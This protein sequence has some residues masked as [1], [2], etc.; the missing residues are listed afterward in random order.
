MS[1]FR[2]YVKR[3]H[4]GL[5]ALLLVLTGGT[6]YAATAIPK[7]AVGSKHVKDNSLRGKDLKDAGLTGADLADGSVAGP[8]LADGSVGGADL[9]D[10]G[11]GAGDLAAGSVDGGAIKDGAVGKADIADDVVPQVMTR[12]TVV[13]LAGG[14]SWL[15]YTTVPGVGSIEFICSTPSNAGARIMAVGGGT[16][17]Y[18]FVEGQD[19]TTGQGAVMVQKGPNAYIVQAQVSSAL[20]ASR[21]IAQSATKSIDVDV[22]VSTY[23]NKCTITGTTTVTD[24]VTGTVPG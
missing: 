23:N 15:N 17:V 6:A 11:V 18:S 12:T 2:D 24:N 16:E 3:H 7:N 20:I 19:L 14:G 5:V 10:G 9:T 1:N 21:I 22:R 8:D 13:P 4:V